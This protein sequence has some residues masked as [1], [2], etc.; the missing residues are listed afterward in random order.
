MV[1]AADRQRAARRI[2]TTTTNATI[3]SAR[4]LLEGGRLM[5][6]RLRLRADRLH[7]HIAID[8]VRR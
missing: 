1:A 2:S 3:R 6:A 8:E 7:V 4:Q 5:A